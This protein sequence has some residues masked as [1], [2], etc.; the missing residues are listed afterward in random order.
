MI[1]NRDD[2]SHVE[3]TNHMTN[4]MSAIVV[5]VVRCW[6]YIGCP[7]NPV[8]VMTTVKFLIGQVIYIYDVACYTDI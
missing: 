1:S 2:I 6:S 8:R 4:D 3:T 7:P 5:M